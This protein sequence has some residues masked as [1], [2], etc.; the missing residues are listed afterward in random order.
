MRL[1]RRYQTKGICRIVR[2]TAREMAGK[3]CSSRR[4]GIKGTLERLAGRFQWKIGKLQ[5]ACGF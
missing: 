2:G 1:S 4:M 5:G 3:I